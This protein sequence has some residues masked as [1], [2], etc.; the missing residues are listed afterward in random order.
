MII[1]QKYLIALALIASV[2]ISVQAQDYDDD[3]GGNQRGNDGYGGFSGGGDDDYAAPRERGIVGADGSDMNPGYHQGGG[4][5]GAGN[6]N[7]DGDDSAAAASHVR[8]S[9][10]RP[11]LIKMIKQSR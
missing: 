7:Y 3:E 5:E 11:H 2:L 8:P 1:Q 4:D 9:I 6:E 10:S